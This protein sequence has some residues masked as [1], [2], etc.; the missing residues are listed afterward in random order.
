MYLFSL[1]HYVNNNRCIGR[2]EKKLF[3]FRGKYKN[4]MFFFLNAMRQVLHEGKNQNHQQQK[5]TIK[6]PHNFYYFRYLK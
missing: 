3:F 2:N 5:N 1:I 4:I 6:T